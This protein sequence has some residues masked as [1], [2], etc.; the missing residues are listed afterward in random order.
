MLIGFV[1]LLMEIVSIFIDEILTSHFP[2]F[3]LI[4]KSM[5]KTAYVLVSSLSW[6]SRER[7]R[8]EGLA[9]RPI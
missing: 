1:I 9:V 7:T 8:I 6:S 4:L 3:W 5:F 2:L